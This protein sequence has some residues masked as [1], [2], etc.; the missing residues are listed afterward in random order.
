MFRKRSKRLN[1]SLIT[2]YIT[3]LALL[4]GPDFVLAAPS[5]SSAIQAPQ[6]TASNHVAV[7]TTQDR[8]DGTTTSLS[9]L[10]TDAGPDHAISL[11]E[12]VLAANETGTDDAITISFDIPTTASGYS[13]NSK[14]W[15]I[16]LENTLPALTRGNI[17]IDG[18]TQT[19]TSAHPPIVIDGT[20]ALDTT[21]QTN[22]FT[23]T[24]ENN[25]LH[26]LT[27][28][29]FFDGGLLIDGADAVNNQVS[30]CY[31]GINATGLSASPNG[32]GIRI[33]NG[34]R[35]NLIGGYTVSERNII[36]G[37]D[38]DTGIALHGA[39]TQAN[40]VAGNWIGISS[41]GQSAIP[42][43][44]AGVRISGQA[45]DNLIGGTNAGAGN[46]ISGNQSGVFIEGSSSNTVA[47][48]TIG[49]AADRSTPLGNENG[50][51]YLTDGAN[52]NLIGGTVTSARNIIAS[53]N[54][55][56]IYIADSGSNQNRVQ[57]NYVGVDQTGTSAGYG[58]VNY[59]IYVG[60]SAQAN[61]IGGTNTQ[62]GNVVAYN[63]AGGV[64]IESSNNKVAGNIIGVGADRSTQLGNQNDGVKVHGDNNIIGPHNLI[65]YN[66]QSGIMADG[67]NITI[68]DNTIDAN[69]RS[70]ICVSGS[71]TAVLQN[72]I[73]WNGGSNGVSADC[74]VQGGIAITGTDVRVEDNVIFANRGSGITVRSGVRNRLLTNSISNNTSAGILLDSGANGN[75]APPV[76]QGVRDNTIVGD[77][78]PECLVEVF[79][80]VGDQGGHF[81]GTTTATAEGTFQVPLSNIDTDSLFVTATQTDAAG[82]TSS[83]ALSVSIAETQVY[84]PMIIR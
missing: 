57:G 9:A 70:G 71:Q 68:S 13:A 23:L 42:N 46:I 75:I 60:L 33:Q 58:N 49:L 39:Q 54:G 56:G 25:R 76:I 80:D 4:Y 52:K 50:G 66:Q 11:R 3:V 65:A 81:A 28:I 8:V 17:T 2:L 83:F 26:R 24:S 18:S 15:T 22:G 55:W 37:N 69:A 48:N 51:V 40:T 36:A 5:N 27:I 79:T 73:R 41:S 59:G 74:A 67:A 14:T 64:F 77:S 6:S 29:N 45:T 72:T 34:A 20:N 10:N 82:N 38:Y 61:I 84:L 62:A 44:Y 35:D 32:T 1:N 16:A 47:G 31:I 43:A 30:G 63:G 21:P 78:C 7:T 19:T 12:A 53:N